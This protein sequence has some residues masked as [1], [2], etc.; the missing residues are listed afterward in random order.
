LLGADSRAPSTD[1][2][3]GG[4]NLALSVQIAPLAYGVASPLAAMASTLSQS[5]FN[6]LLQ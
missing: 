4:S 6:K 2:A 3:A 1:S 5:I